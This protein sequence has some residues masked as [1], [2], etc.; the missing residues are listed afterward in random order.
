MQHP[1]DIRILP[2]NVYDKHYEFYFVIYLQFFF[3]PPPK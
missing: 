3:S 2:L 1:I